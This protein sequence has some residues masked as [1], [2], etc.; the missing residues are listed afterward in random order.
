M[1]KQKLLFLLAAPALSLVMAQ[2]Q[3]QVEIMPGGGYLGVKIRDVTSDDAQALRLP[4]ESGVYVEAVDE[5]SPAETAG[6]QERDVITEFSGVPVISVIQFRRLVAET[7]P[8]R[9]VDL[10]LVRNGNSLSKTARIEKRQGD[11]RFGRSFGL[12]IPDAPDNFHFQLPEFERRRDGTGRGFVIGP[13]RPRLG[14]QGVELGEQMAQFLGVPGTSG[15][16]VLEVRKDSP[17]EKAGL[18]A[19]DVITAVGGKSISSLPELSASVGD[20]TSDLSIIRDQRRQSL[21]ITIEQERRRESSGESR[22]L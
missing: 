10:R 16:L 3:P 21:K 5:G 2:A 13:T 7:P 22:R 9:E 12:Q 14:I 19:G 8:N 1:I 11:R 17:A 15:V 4:R 20:G 18:Q 6:I